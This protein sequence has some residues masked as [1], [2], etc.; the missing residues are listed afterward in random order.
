MF[1]ICVPEVSHVE[2]RVGKVGVLEVGPIALGRIE[3]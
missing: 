2:G 3:V 1:E